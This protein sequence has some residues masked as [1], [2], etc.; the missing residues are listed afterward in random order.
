MENLGRALGRE[1]MGSMQHHLKLGD[2]KRKKKLDP[3]TWKQKQEPSLD[4]NFTICS[5]PKLMGLGKI[6]HKHVLCLFEQTLFFFVCR[7][8]S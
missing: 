4:R 2:I 6:Q 3:E 7:D 5:T 1:K 8:D